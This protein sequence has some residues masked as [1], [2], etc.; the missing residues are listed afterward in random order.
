MTIARDLDLPSDSIVVFDRGYAAYNWFNTLN[1][2]GI[3]FVTRQKSR[4]AYT[5]FERNSVN[6][7]QG[8]TSDQTIRIKGEYAK[9]CPFNMRR[10]GYR[11]PET[12]KHYTFLTNN[13]SLSAMTIAR[14]YQSRWQIELFFKWIKQNLRIKTYLGT[15]K[16]AVLT[17]IWIAMC[18]YLILCYIKFA[19]KLGFSLQQILRLLQLNLFE[20]R[21]LMALLKPP[22]VLK[23]ETIFQ[24]SLSIG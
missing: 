18:I 1:S 21:D 9:T 22:L 11:D 24:T 10:I 15:S 6:K 12:G 20:R 5:V 16:N 7:K 2:K 3:F 4:A 14:I 23:E 17:Q 19:N 13:F 8:L